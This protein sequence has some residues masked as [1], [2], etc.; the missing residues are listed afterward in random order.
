MERSAKGRLDHGPAVAVIDI[1]SNSIRLVI[2]EGLTRAPT[3][4]F[5]EKVLAGLGR[6]VQT[7]G[8]LAQDAI[9]SALAALRRFRGL[10]DT[11]KVKKI[12]AIATAACRDARNGAAFIK[13]AERICRTTIS[14]LSGKRE[15]HLTALGVVSGIYKPDGI[16]GDLG[17]GSLELVNVHG[18]RVNAGITLPLGGLALQDI[19]HRSIKKAEKFVEDTF[20]NLDMLHSGEGRTFYAVGGTW[21]ALA[22]LHMW[23]T[24]YPFHVMHNYRIPAREALEFSRLVHRVDTDTL[25]KIEV[26]NAAR[27]PLLAYAALVMEN[28]IRT[29]KPSDVVF[30]VMG[31][32]EGLLYELLKPSERALDPLISA[33]ADLNVLRSRSPRHGEELIAWTDAFMASSGLDET[34]DERRLRHAACLL[35][36]IG[37]R[38]HPD[39]RGEQ[40]MNIIAHGAFSAIDHPGRAYLALSIYFRHAGLS[41]EDLSPRLREL[42]TARILDRAR[43]LGAA[44]RV[45]Y[46]LTAGQGGVLPKTPMQVKR[47]KLTLSLPGLYGQLVAERLTSRL[48]QLGRLV[49][50]EVEI[51]T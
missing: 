49:G 35:A 30:S 42:A 18:S 45:A 36:D 23:Q 10:C 29:I 25:S 33:S 34:A 32:R 46:I 6:E 41:E 4:I 17:G 13:Q 28:L 48:R 9:N 31:V 43:V 47:G 24:G 40:S 7:T 12:W 19:S 20:K 2:Y 11:L 51:E 22:R 8:L 50:R 26:V 16:V 21:R 15:A 44:M 3:P 37:W 5:N 39:Y 27:R 38:A 1:G 14:I